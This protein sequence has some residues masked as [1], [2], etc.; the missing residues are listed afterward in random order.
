[1]IS[2]ISVSEEKRILVFIV[3]ATEH[4]HSYRA[5]QKDASTYY[6]RSDSN[7]IEARNGLLRELLI[8]KRELEPWDRRI[9]HSST[10]ENIDL[11][12][13]RDYLQEMGLW[14]SHKALE[15]YLSD[16]EK[17][18]DF[19]PPLMGKKGLDN[20][21]RPKNF[22]LLMFGKKLLNFFEGAYA[23]FSVY[24]S[25]DRSEPIGKRLLI[26]GTI[27]QQARQL[28]EL[29]NAESYT[30]FDKTTESPNQVKYPP[31]ALKEAV[32]NDL[33]HR[34]YESDQP[35]RVTVFID[36]IEIYSPGCLPVQVDQEKFKR[37]QA[38]A[39][40]RNQS[41]NYLF[42]RLQL[43]QAE[44]QGIPTILKTMRNEGCPDP[45]FEFGYESVICIIPAH[46]RYQYL[47]H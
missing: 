47:N 34:D 2:E 41:L 11:V 15:D 10:I 4:A 21:L 46:P 36:R 3:P 14:S 6:I 37:G 26:Q 33:V 27:V 35:V 8:R 17:L 32:V 42:N 25:Q 31:L 44:G 19:T 12:I 24:K 30:V 20:T 39:Y 9:N 28:I 38:T 5:N 45:I 40:W 23:I 43:A 1:V 13:F 16:T 18:A 7:T 29:L 22:T